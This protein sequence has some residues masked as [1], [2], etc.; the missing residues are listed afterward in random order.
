MYSKMLSARSKRRRVQTEISLINDQPSCS[1]SSFEP[2]NNV[3]EL[4]NFDVSDN[5]GCYSPL[6]DPNS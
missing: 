5:V 1:K 2:P 3:V 4:N 6:Q